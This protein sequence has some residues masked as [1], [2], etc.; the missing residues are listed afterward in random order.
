M[1]DSSAADADTRH[2]VRPRRKRKRSGPWPGHADWETLY[3]LLSPGQFLDAYEDGG[4]VVRCM[5]PAVFRPEAVPVSRAVFLDLLA[6]GWLARVSSRPAGAVTAT[7]YRL[8]LRGWYAVRRVRPDLTVKAP[9][10]VRARVRPV[11]KSHHAP[12]CLRIMGDDA[13]IWPPA[14]MSCIISV[15]G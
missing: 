11:P 3:S 9:V 15:W 2:P 14:P 4:K 8:S 10:G 7:S 5:L 13:K 6:R 1:T 12:D